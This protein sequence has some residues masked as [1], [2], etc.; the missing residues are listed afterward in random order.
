MRIKFIRMVLFISLIIPSA[1]AF[2]G[3]TSTLSIVGARQQQHHNQKR[4]I[5][6]SVIGGGGC[7]SSNS[8]QKTKKSIVLS[9]QTTPP[10]SQQLHST[11]TSLAMATDESK[12]T[13]IL[14]HQI[15]TKVGKSA[16][17]LVSLSFFILLTY[18]RDAII[19]TLWIGAIGNA[20]LSKVIKRIL[21]HERPAELHEDDNNI[22]LK[23]SDGGMPS[24]HAMSLG[25]IGTSL[26][27]GIIPQQYQVGAG[28]AMSIYTALALQYRIQSKLHTLEQ[29]IVGLVLGIGNALAWLKFA[30][31]SDGSIGFILSYVQ[32][33]FVSPETGLFSRSALSIP[34]VVG[35]LVVGSFERRIALWLKNKKDR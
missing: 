32:S 9:S 24:S 30:L 25:F 2:C 20:I 16:S 26:L 35:I 34:I 19:L 1:Y 6:E 7:H 18:K 15:T 17:S 13:T 12:P 33:N 29:V 5:K 23:P 31:G 22:K 3:P 14:S 28:V 11:S 21:N 8:L 10:Y 4:V 27:F